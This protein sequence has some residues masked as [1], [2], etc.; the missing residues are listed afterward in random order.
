MSASFCEECGTTLA[1]GLQFCTTCGHA[2]ASAVA[3]IEAPPAVPPPAPVVT[4]RTADP[5]RA[6]AGPAAQTPAPAR[7]GTARRRVAIGTLVVTVLAAGGAAV[8]HFY[9]PTASAVASVSEEAVRKHFQDPQGA[10]P[11]IQGKQLSWLLDGDGQ[12]SKAQRT[13]VSVHADVRAVKNDVALTDV[14]VGYRAALVPL[15][16]THAPAIEKNAGDIPVTEHLRVGLRRGSDGTWRPDWIFA[17]RANVRFARAATPADAELGTPT[18]LATNA[19]TNFATFRSSDDDDTWVAA[20]APFYGV[21]RNTAGDPLTQ[22]P[23]LSAAADASGPLAN[24]LRATLF[25]NNAAGEDTG[26]LDIRAVNAT[27]VLAGRATRSAD[28]QPG[29]PFQH[30]EVTGS[31]QVGGGEFSGCPG[32]GGSSSSPPRR[33]DGTVRFSAELVRSRL[34]ATSLWYLS[35][36]AFVSGGDLGSDTTIPI[37]STGLGE[38]D[39]VS[40]T[41]IA[42]WTGV[43]IQDTAYGS[44]SS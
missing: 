21:I 10:S 38:N 24:L 15:R 26:Q 29:A 2:V 17:T 5:P 8:A 12:V 20:Q 16:G 19:V 13:A 34:S 42:D 43:P 35:R 14:S 9:S 28:I 40:V 22:A 30:V 41:S 36:L 1:V 3:V 39:H 32:F 6:A 4:A 37:F 44:C 23:E 11:Q 31:L 7:A 33:V 25:N 18:T 27:R